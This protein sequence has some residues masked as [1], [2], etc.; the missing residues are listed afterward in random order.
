M[1]L[2]GVDLIPH[3]CF[4]HVGHN[5][6]SH[7]AGPFDDRNRAWFNY[8]WRVFRAGTATAKVTISDWAEPDR[9]G[10]PIGRQIMC[11]FAH[12]RP[13]FPDGTE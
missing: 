9:P 1:T 10:G 12:V 4:T 2:D 7:H 5:C 8:H 11:N 6:Y 13:Y 3:K